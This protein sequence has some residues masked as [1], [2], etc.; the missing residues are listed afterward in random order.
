MVTSKLHNRMMAAVV[1]DDAREIR[2]L[3]KDGFDVTGIDMN[4]DTWLDVAIARKCMN[5]AAAILMRSGSKTT[6]LNMVD[7]NGDT[8][9]DKAIGV[10][11]EKFLAM[12]LVASDKLDLLHTN[13]KGVSTLD[14]LMK[15]NSK[16]VN[17]ALI[18]NHYLAVA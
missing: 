6:L 16:T 17:D 15:L 8:V 12:L 1:L 11:S 18:S 14:L 7:V 2:T 13:S 4:G 9:I 5:A 10:V 3:A